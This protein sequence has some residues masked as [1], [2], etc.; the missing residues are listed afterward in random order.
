MNR[1]ESV[2]DGTAS[3][4]T[5]LPNDGNQ[6]AGYK[7][8]RWLMA[9]LLV[10]FVAGCGNG[11][12]GRDP[13][14]GGADVGKAT[15][16]SLISTFP[17]NGAVAV[18]TNTVSTA[19]FNK[20]MS[21]A[22]V[23]TSFTVTCSAPCA[24]PVAGTV[25]YIN[26]TA[27]FTPTGNSG[28]FLPSTLYTSTITTG[29]KD[30]AGNA[31]VSGLI[32]NPWSWTTG[33][34]P[35]FAAPTVILT[36]PFDGASSV[37]VTQTIKAT[38]N[39]PMNQF[40]M[41]PANFTLE[42]ASGVPVAGTVSYDVLNNIATFS[43]TASLTLNTDYKATVT[44]G[45]KDLAGNALVEP[46]V[47]GLPKPNPWTFKTAAALPAIPIGIL[48]PFA[49]ASFSPITD[50]SATKVNGDVVIDT[51]LTCQGTGALMAVGQT[52][53]FGPSC[54]AGANIITNNAGD[55]VITQ[56]WNG[57]SVDTPAT[58]FANK[59]MIKLT[60]VWNSLS[61]ASMAGGIVLGCPTIGSTG[62]GGALIGC[63]G[64]ATLP[65]GT[66][67][68]NT[69]SSIGI[70]GDLTLDGGGDQSALFVFQA[71]S[72]TVIT[73]AGAASPGVHTR[74]LLTN[75]AK[76]SNVWWYVGSSATLGTYTE[77]QGNILASAAITMDIGATSCGRL[78]S[79]AAGTGGF[80]FD[81][82]VVSVPGDTNAPPTA[83]GNSPQ[84]CQ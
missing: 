47:L 69:G 4:S 55:K 83:V 44:S 27:T 48:S 40:T 45:A 18:P 70:S 52:N 19:T 57:T 24:S 33:L 14:L 11:G 41:I 71:P 60:A 3:H 79:G 64:N 30:L 66:Y 21:S 84:I 15:A 36:N 53:D 50:V 6:V 12:G 75:G 80:T 28:K 76:A 42:T 29:A 9:L 72:S 10:A 62:G 63:A 54:N 78:L 39:E 2:T 23:L 74:I 77:F 22:T 46:A 5:W 1:F 81:N 43:P 17:V 67:I 13:I 58:S 16:P 8:L 56:I 82:N 49:M 26:N 51:G 31:L 35:T 34:G 61:P 7:P 65:P 68:S 59:V 32:Q 20:A 25:T 38:F 37:P 73:A